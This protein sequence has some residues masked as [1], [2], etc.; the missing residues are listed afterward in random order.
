[1][2]AVC[3]WCQREMGTAPCSDGE[4]GAVL[5]EGT[6]YLRVPFGPPPDLHH[7]SYIYGIADQQEACRAIWAG[8]P[9]AWPSNC[10]DCGTPQGALHHPGCDGEACPRCLNQAISC[11]C[12]WGGE[13]SEPRSWRPGPE[14]PCAR[15]ARPDEPAKPIPPEV[16]A[17]P[18][19]GEI[20]AG[21]MTEL[22]EA[23][24]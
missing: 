6:A 13:D 19:Q 12:R 17:L 4:G 9:A 22:L 11:G 10:R 7:P 23:G 20:I 14:S 5:V 1:M 16:A 3:G 15:R 18:S 24:Q 2:G 8:W 21:W